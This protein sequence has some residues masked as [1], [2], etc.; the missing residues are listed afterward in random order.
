MLSLVASGL[1]DREIAAELGK[2]EHAVTV[3]VDQLIVKTN[4]QNRIELALFGL[5]KSAPRLAGSHRH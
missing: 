3:S 1:D 2:T 4:A 5:A